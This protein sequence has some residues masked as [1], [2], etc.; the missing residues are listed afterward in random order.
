[1]SQSRFQPSA[2]HGILPPLTTPFTSDEEIDEKALRK[3]VHFM[4][5]QGVHGL[6]SGGS[7][8]EGFTLSTD[9]LRRIVAVTCEEA[10]GRM[11]VIAG[12]IVDSTRQAVER[13][14]AVADL[15]VD[16][17]QITPVHYIY[18]P[19]DE[20]TF[21]HFK[22]VADE[23]GIPI[24]IYNVVPWNYISPKLLL[25][26]MREIPLVFGVKQSASDVK[27]LADLMLYAGPD[28]RI[29]TAIDSLLYPTF[30]LG[31]H[32][33][34]SQILSAVPGACVRLWDAVQA[35]DHAA[36]AA[37][38]RQLLTLWNAIYS[39]NR[40]AVTKYVQALQG[41]PS[42]LPRAPIVEATPAQKE[43]VR[44]PL[45]DLIGPDRMQRSA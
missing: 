32:G 31:A 41:C 42:G 5:D 15:G 13:A 22:T 43:A 38:H 16:A 21:K 11:P 7:A 30:A 29:Y 33:A 28:D 36:A 10:A 45:A 20:A 39:E 19:D 34:I 4:M 18:K 6:V 17:L 40:V 25:R 3:Q 27:T 23:V 8:G 35:G 12:I 1:M 26:M 14:R 37:L 9:E 44:Q 2:I 24:I